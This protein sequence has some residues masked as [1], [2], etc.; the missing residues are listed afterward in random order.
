MSKYQIQKKNKNNNV[1]SCHSTCLKKVPILAV[2]WRL[3]TFSR[4]AIFI[5]FYARAILKIV[6]TI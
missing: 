1:L 5:Q 6:N 3:L 4:P 2:R